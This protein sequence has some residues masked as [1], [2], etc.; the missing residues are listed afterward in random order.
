MQKAEV[1]KRLEDCGVVAVVRGENEQQAMKIVD[2]C[3]KAGIVGIEITFTVPGALDIIKALAK[4]YAPEEV[5]IGAG[6][7]LDPETA[8][9]AILA[10]A[11][12]VVAPCLNA[13]TV[14]MCLRYQVACMPGAMTI[15]E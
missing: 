14:K 6:T 8:R 12:F 2:A 11:T 10:G 3:I 7:V 15:K 5:L 13:E 4:K 9:A 1:L